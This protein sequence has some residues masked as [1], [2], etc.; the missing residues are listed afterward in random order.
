ML[1]VMK[2]MSERL[3]A[4]PEAKVKISDVY[5]PSYDPDMNVGIREWCQHITTAMV[6][7]NFT[8][9]EIRMK[10]GSLLKGRARLWVDNWLISTT[11]WLEL[12]EVLI[13]TF[14]PENRYSRDIVRFKEHNYDNTKDITQFLS[15]AWVLWRRITKDKLSDND[16]VEAVIGCIA[17][18]RLR[19]ELLNVRATSVPELISVAS[20]IRST[21][22]SYPNTSITSQGTIKRTRYDKFCQVCKRNGHDAR[23]CYYRKPN[24]YPQSHT[25][26]ERNVSK[27][28]D[29]SPTCSY[30]QK[31]GHTFETCFKRTEAV[32]S[33]I[34]CVGSTKVNLMPVLIENFKLLAMFD[35]GAE[36]SVIRESL[37]SKLPGRRTDLVRYL[38]G[39]GQFT[40]VSLSTLTTVCVISDLRVEIQFHI[41]PD[42]EICSDVLIGVNLIENTNLSVIVN[43]HGV[44]L[45]RQPAICHVMSRSDKFNNL[46]CDLT[47]QDQINRLTILLNKYENLF[48]YGYPRSRVNTGVLQI[49][50]KDNES[51]DMEW[52]QIE[53]RRDDLLRPLIDSM[54]SDHPAANYTLREEEYVQ[55]KMLAAAEY[56][57]QRFE[58]S[59]GKVHSF[60]RGDYVLIKNNPRNQ[61]S[62]DLKYTEPYEIYK[63]LE[64]DRYMV[65]RVTGRGRPRKVAHDQLR[66]APNPG[67]AGTVSADYIDDPPHHDSPLNGEASED[68]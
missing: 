31:I 13:T 24:N 3:S 30:C 67:A 16:A 62:L 37:A 2:H 57:K 14:E 29:T 65:K 6:T 68:L 58:K 42:Y 28:S 53:Q 50:L 39:L 38:K 51:K 61:T 44:T 12:R 54:S 63:V 40:V 9:Y 49:R 35:T 17:D 64:H 36:C 22:R 33:N 52:L 1:E 55:Q 7:Y 27:G 4:Q 8:D 48:I 43:S 18:E 23:D 26:T 45:L 41:V 5:L 20:S 11:T 66:P 56:D 25:L 47:D 60:K 19:I 10:V 34:N 32:V 15:Q 46:N 59:K 21:K